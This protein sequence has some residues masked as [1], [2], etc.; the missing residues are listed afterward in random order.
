M[1]RAS[2]RCLVNGHQSL[3]A[4]TRAQSGGNEDSEPCL[5]SRKML[6][7]QQLTKCHSFEALSPSCIRWQGS[8]TNRFDPLVPMSKVKISQ[9]QSAALGDRVCQGRRRCDYL[10][11]ALPKKAAVREIEELENQRSKA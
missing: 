9:R 4:D 2:K 8:C 7:P 6:Q 1:A 3:K 5:F 11:S 10:A